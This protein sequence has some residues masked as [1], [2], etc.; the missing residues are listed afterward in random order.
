[1]ELKRLQ[2]I[3]DEVDVWSNIHH[4]RDVVLELVV[5]LRES[6]EEV[7]LR[8]EFIEARKDRASAYHSFWFSKRL[9]RREEE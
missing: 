1:M 8:K 9:E 5:A 3:E 4:M 2:E 7:E 6:Q